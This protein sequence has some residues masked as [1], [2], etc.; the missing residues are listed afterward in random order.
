MW[1]MIYEVDDAQSAA[2]YNLLVWATP[3]AGGRVIP[4]EY[5]KSEIFDMINTLRNIN[6]TVDIFIEFCEVIAG[7]RF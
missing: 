2:L 6:E 5:D 4:I 3:D 7:M 1:D